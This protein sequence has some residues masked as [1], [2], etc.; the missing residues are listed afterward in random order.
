MLLD[1]LSD[2][3]IQCEKDIYSKSEISYEPTVERVERCPVPV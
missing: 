1:M 2:M 3:L